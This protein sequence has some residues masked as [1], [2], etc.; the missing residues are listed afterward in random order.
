MDKE[1][2]MDKLTISTIFNLPEKSPS[3]HWWK[4]I[5]QGSNPKRRK[6]EGY[7]N[8]YHHSEQPLWGTKVTL[9][10]TGGWGVFG[11]MAE[12]RLRICNENK[13]N[14]IIQYLYIIYHAFSH[15]KFMLYGW[16]RELNG[17]RKNLITWEIKNIHHKQ[18]GL[19]F[20][21]SWAINQASDC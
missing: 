11:A 16:M 5:S 12:V 15:M 19:I 18:D 1:K 8:G 3:N 6:E 21:L 10:T 2:P 20:E 9:K 4:Q 17:G 13:C 7:S 14:Q